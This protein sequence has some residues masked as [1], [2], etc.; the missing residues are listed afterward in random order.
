MKLSR[1]DGITYN[2]PCEVS[3]L[4]D[5]GD[6]VSDSWDTRASG[7]SCERVQRVNGKNVRNSSVCRISLGN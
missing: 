7:I 3:K 1:G 5:P 2:W 4:V 6:T